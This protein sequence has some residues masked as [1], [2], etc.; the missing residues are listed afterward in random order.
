MPV[1]GVVR[2]SSA[3]ARRFCGS[4]SSSNTSSTRRG[5]SSW[6]GSSE[7]IYGQEVARF[8]PGLEEKA[9][10]IVTSWEE[11][12]DAW[13]DAPPAEPTTGG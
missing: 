10:E 12:L 5:R 11:K 1:T 6:R 3:C 4:S 13:L 7:T 2:R 9:M 8:E